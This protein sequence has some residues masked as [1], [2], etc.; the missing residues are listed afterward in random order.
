MDGKGLRWKQEDRGGSYW[1]APLREE[2]SKAGSHGE[3]SWAE[4]RC[5]QAVVAAAIEWVTQGRKWEEPKQ[6]GFHTSWVVGL[7]LR[8][9]T[10]GEPG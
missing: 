9:E 1:V 5:L 7:S 4:S 3:N 10:G 2:P 8:W 6:E